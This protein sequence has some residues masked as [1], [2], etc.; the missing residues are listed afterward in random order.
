MGLL[1]SI[2]VLGLLAIV[3]HILVFPLTVIGD[4]HNTFSQTL[5]VLVTKLAT[6][7]FV[8][9]RFKGLEHFRPGETFCIVANHTSTLDAFIMA[10]LADRDFRGII[11][12]S[13]FYYPIFGPLFWFGGFIGVNRHVPGSRNAARQKTLALLKEGVSV[14]YFPEGTRSAGPMLPFQRGAFKTA[15][16]AGVPILPITLSGL[17]AALPLAGIPS[18]GWFSVEVTIHEPVPT[19]GLCTEAGEDSDVSRL[20]DRV[21][22]IVGSG[23]RPVDYYAGTAWEKDEA[24][25]LEAWSGPSSFESANDAV[26]ADWKKALERAARRVGKGKTTEKEDT[27]AK[28]KAA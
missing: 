6:G 2:C 9:V 19:E 7:P 25:F 18:L 14:L 5:N 27:G 3:V 11:K 16:E 12:S 13:L 28:E 26:G 23:L 15:I 21:R 4:P 10:L 24:A 20:S 1:L 17:R 8:R 22:A